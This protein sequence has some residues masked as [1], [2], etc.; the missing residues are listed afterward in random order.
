MRRGGSDMEVITLRSNSY[1]IANHRAPKP[2]WYWAR[3]PLHPAIAKFISVPWV[4]KGRHTRTADHRHMITEHTYGTR[5]IR[6]TESML[7]HAYQVSAWLALFFLVSAPP[8]VLLLPFL[9]LL[10]LH[11]NNGSKPGL[12]HSRQVFNLLSGYLSRPA[13]LIV[14]HRQKH[15]S[16]PS[17]HECNTNGQ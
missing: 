9:I 11:C 17:S 13:A 6:C 14:N 16:W 7:Y 4:C 1:S 8:P 5:K 12:V 10:L 2:V 15:V 3:A